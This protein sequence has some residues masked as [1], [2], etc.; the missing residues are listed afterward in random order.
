MHASGPGGVGK[1]SWPT[2]KPFRSPVER[3]C[4]KVHIE[5]VSSCELRASA[6]RVQ[7]LVSFAVGSKVERSDVGF[8]N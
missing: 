5:A 7:A 3:T 2:K 8:Q 6:V 4:F 1:G